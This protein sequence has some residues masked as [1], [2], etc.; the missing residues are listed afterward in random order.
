[1]KFRLKNSL[2]VWALAGWASGVAAQEDCQARINKIE[3]VA[4]IQAALLC[5]QGQITSESARMR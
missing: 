1:M 3:K 2:L 4:D 5:V